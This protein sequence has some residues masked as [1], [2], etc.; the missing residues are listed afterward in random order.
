M[1]VGEWGDGGSRTVFGKGFVEKDKVSEA[2]ADTERGFLEGLEVSLR[3]LCQL[4]FSKSSVSVDVEAY[5]CSDE[6]GYIGIF[7]AIV[8]LQRSIHRTI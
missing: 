4:G 6:I 3:A 7:G 8:L 5:M 1:F 2:T